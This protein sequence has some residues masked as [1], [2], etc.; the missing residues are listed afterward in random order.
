LQRISHIVLHPTNPN[1]IYA[2]LGIFGVVKS[3]DG[4]VTWSNKS[5][6]LPVAEHAPLALD[7]LAPDTL[8][9]GSGYPG[10]LYKTTDG[11]DHWLPVGDP[12]LMR[13]CALAVSPTTSGTVH[14]GTCDQGLAVTTDGG[15]TVVGRAAS[16]WGEWVTSI[17][18][19]PVTP[20]RVMWSS[21]NVLFQ[22]DDDGD[23]R[24]A[25]YVSA[26]S[27]FVSLGYLPGAASTTVAAV[28]QGGLV[29]TGQD[30]DGSWTSTEHPEL[31]PVAAMVP[32]A[33]GQI[34][35]GGH[36]GVFRVDGALVEPHNTG[37]ETLPVMAAAVSAQDPDLVYA[38]LDRDGIYRTRNG[39]LD[40]TRVLPLDQA[41]EMAVDGAN[42]QVVYVLG[43]YSMMRSVDGGDTWTPL[44]VP[45]PETLMRLQVHP[46]VADGLAITT[47]G[48]LYR[49]T[50]R[51]DTWQLVP[52]VPGN[53][54]VDALGLDPTDGDK[55]YAITTTRIFVTA[56]AGVSWSPF[57][58]TASPAG[59]TALA[60]AAGNTQ[61]VCVSSVIDV[62]CSANGGASWVTTQ[63]GVPMYTIT[64][65]TSASGDEVTAASFGGYGIAMSTDAGATFRSFNDGL[66][67]A[68]IT[69][70]AISAAAPA[71]PVVATLGGIFR[72]RRTP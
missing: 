26:T 8:Y 14:I 53:L 70:V 28:T 25:V 13:V 23:T 54:Q 15:Q 30:V 67:N 56:D 59:P 64:L 62:T 72:L 1:V 69:A 44:V 71:R 12:T 11:G 24:S 43:S 52:P 33:S 35:V 39:G 32:A 27:G 49:S 21:F 7:P 63:S 57:F 17:A 6:G 22:S 60:F 16:Q 47:Y 55:L 45:T 41:T 34:R 9:T 19:S 58:A 65:W 3:T 37:L 20:G 5:L 61:R 4:G 51:G 18:P 50:D 36:H 10:P 68:T 48:G 29:A 38:A 42:G 40:W 2:S 31:S 46:R 66:G